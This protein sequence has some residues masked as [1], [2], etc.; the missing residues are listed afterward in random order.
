VDVTVVLQVYPDV[1]LGTATTYRTYQFGLYATPIPL[2][3]EPTVPLPQGI[4]ADLQIS[5]PPMPV[6]AAPT[7]D[8]MFSPTGPT[9]STT[10]VA[11]NTNVYIWIR[12]LS[13]V[14][15]PNGAPVTSMNGQYPAPPGDFPNL[16]AYADGFRRSGEQLI[17]GVRAG[18]FV[19]VAPVNVPPLTGV[20]PPPQDPYTF[21]RQQ[22]GK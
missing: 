1:Y 7:Y 3:A 20:Y 6:P 4:V 8:V 21:A 14:T 12:D 9:V 2:L 18:G 16:P 22:L 19:G 15:N 5:Y 13:K 17:V 10:N 11:A